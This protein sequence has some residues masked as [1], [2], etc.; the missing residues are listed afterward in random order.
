[1]HMYGH[2]CMYGYIKYAILSVYVCV[3]I[4]LFASDLWYPN[5]NEL[6]FPNFVI[7]F[8]P[9]FSAVFAS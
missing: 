1:M 2:A 3:Y 5:S 9:V 8:L 7:L 4:N 6:K